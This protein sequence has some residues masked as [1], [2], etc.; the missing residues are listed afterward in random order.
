MGFLSFR[1]AINWDRYILIFSKFLN[2]SIL[3]LK[4][5]TS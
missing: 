1:G 3:N 5:K 2:V 4:L